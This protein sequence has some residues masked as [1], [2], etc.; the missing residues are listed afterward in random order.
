[1][2]PIPQTHKPGRWGLW[3]T[4][5]KLWL[6]NAN[7]PLTYDDRDHARVAATICTERVGYVV[8]VKQIEDTPDV[9]R[10]I[11]TPEMSSEQAIDKIEGRVKKN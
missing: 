5:D 3:D 8:R 10:D 6:G 9:L 1:M 2:K 4:K 11:I 7:G